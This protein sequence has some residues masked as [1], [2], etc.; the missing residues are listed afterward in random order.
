MSLHIRLGHIGFDRLQQ[1]ARQGILP[2]KIAG[3]EHPKCTSCIFGKAKRKPWRGVKTPNKLF[4]NTIDWGNVVSIDQLVSS[5]P[6]LVAQSKGKPMLKRHYIAT[7]FVVHVS[8]LDYVYIHESTT[9]EEAIQAKA[10][11]KRFA[12]QHGVKI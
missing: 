4:T 12:A 2:R 10:A 5:T 1:A 9:A 6:G 8:L 3:I 11:F 7:I